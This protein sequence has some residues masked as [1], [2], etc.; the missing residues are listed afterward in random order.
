MNKIFHSL[1]TWVAMTLKFHGDPSQMWVKY[2]FHGQKIYIYIALACFVFKFFLQLSMKWVFSTVLVCKTIFEKMW[3]N[4]YKNSGILLC[5]VAQKT[6]LLITQGQIICIKILDDEMTFSTFL[7]CLV[8]L[9][10][11]ADSWLIM[12]SQWE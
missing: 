4:L 2:F 3:P 11:T 5:C 6:T 12:S 7:W 10:Q 8:V 9:S 1:L